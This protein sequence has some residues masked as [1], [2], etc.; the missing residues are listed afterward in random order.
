M[1]DKLIKKK[2]TL[3]RFIP[4]LPETKPSKIKEKLSEEEV[5]K[6][7]VLP[8]LEATYGSSMVDHRFQRIPV[9]FGRETRF[10]DSIIYRVRLG[11][12]EPYIIVETKAEGEALDIGQAESYAVALKAPFFLVTD[13]KYWVWYKTGE[14][15]GESKKLKPNEMPIPFPV[16]KAKIYPFESLSEFKRILQQCHDIIWR[17]EGYDPAQSFDEM[18]KILFIKMFDERTV[19]EGRQKEHRFKIYPNEPEEEV[20]ARVKSLFESA[21]ETFPEIFKEAEREY[22]QLVTLNLKDHTIYEVVKKL[23]NYS[24]TKTEVDI[25]GSTYEFFLKGSFRGV[26]GQYFTPREVVEFMVHMVEPKRTHLVCDPA[27]GSGGFLVETMKIVWQQIDYLY[28]RGI[29]NNRTKEKTNFATRNLFGMDLNAR[30]SWVAKMN[31]V[32]HGNGHGNVHHHDALVDSERVREW[33][34]ESES[35]D[36]ILTNPP[37]GSKVTN[38]DILVSYELGRGR[39]V[40]LTEVLF[41]ERCIRLLKQG[42]ILG[43]VVPD[44]ILTNTKL[45]YVRE[46]IKDNTVIKAI[47]SLPIETFQPYGSGMKTSLLFLQKRDFEG[48]LRQGDVFMAIARNIGYDAVGKPTGKNDLP[49]ILKLYQKRRDPNERE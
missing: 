31:M 27:C 4:G 29:L 5:W 15:Q 24:L 39:R 26:M 11:K 48:K 8:F 40:Q 7:K 12:R 9:R 42:G 28:E 21:K 49:K 32:M 37:F 13:G 34:F 19:E 17:A 14:R 45:R 38:Q 44:G 20:V 25:K 46:F 23:G 41:L 2:E 3:E 16:T 43:I 1:R 22:P 47:I 18:S 6:K 36:I 10:A 30:M 35:F 33:G